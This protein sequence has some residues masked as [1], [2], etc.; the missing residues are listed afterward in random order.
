VRKVRKIIVEKGRSHDGRE[1][2]VRRQEQG[3]KI[4]SD[5]FFIWD[6]LVGCMHGGFGSERIKDEGKEGGGSVTTKVGLCL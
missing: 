3:L 1:E 5:V 2:D 4:R 6:L